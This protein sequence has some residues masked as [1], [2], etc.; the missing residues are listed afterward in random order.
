MG[1]YKFVSIKVFER[2]FLTF[3]SEKDWFLGNVLGIEE[4]FGFF[5]E[6]IREIESAVSADLFGELGFHLQNIILE[7]NK[8]KSRPSEGY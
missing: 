3:L 5:D 2:F 8:N 4:W 6:F 1:V 7:L